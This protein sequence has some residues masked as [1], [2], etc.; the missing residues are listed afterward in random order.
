MDY[1]EIFSKRVDF[2]YPGEKTEI[3]GIYS[4]IKAIKELA[5]YILI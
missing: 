3:I 5:L 2:V 4:N 1:K